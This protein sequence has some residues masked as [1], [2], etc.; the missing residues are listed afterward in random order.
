V[1]PVNEGLDIYRWRG[2]FAQSFELSVLEDTQ[3]LFFNYPL[4]GGSSY[5][6]HDTRGSL[7]WLREDG[8][9]ITSG[10]PGATR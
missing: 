9:S 7:G 8:G 10:R 2:H 5:Q 6:F 3:R 1:V 4:A